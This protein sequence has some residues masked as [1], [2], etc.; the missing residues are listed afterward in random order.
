ML[1]VAQEIDGFHDGVGDFRGQVFP[2]GHMTQRGNNVNGLLLGLFRTP[3]EF[4]NMPWL[5]TKY[6]LHR[7]YRLQNPTPATAG[8]SRGF[9]NP[10]FTLYE[11]L[12]DQ[13]AGR[14]FGNVNAEY[15]ATNAKSFG[16]RLKFDAKN[17]FSSD[18]HA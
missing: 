4:N 16:K 15:L 13:K 5:D 6:G 12:N 14:S 2:R 11:E 7:S 9:N 8:A 3:P 18:P 10:F 1:L 17:R